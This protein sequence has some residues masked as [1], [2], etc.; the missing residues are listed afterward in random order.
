MR[1]D[2]ARF[3]AADVDGPRAD[4]DAEAFTGTTAQQLAV[5]RAGAAAINAL[6]LLSPKVDA[7]DARIALDQ[8]FDIVS[9]VMGNRLDGNVI[10]RIHLDLR[11]EELTE[12]APVHCVSICR[13]VNGKLAGRI[14]FEPKLASQAC[15]YLPRLKPRRRQQE[16]RS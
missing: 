15:R 8:A 6:L 12:I 4:V 16:M 14:W 1:E 9:G 13:Q 2:V 3:G 5:N 11:L 10:A 7:F